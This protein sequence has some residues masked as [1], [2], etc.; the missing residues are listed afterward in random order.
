MYEPLKDADALIILTDWDEFR[1]PNWD[2]VSSLLKNPII[3]DGR[4]MF[5]PAAMAAKG[6]VYHSVGRG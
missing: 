4:N 1:E 5:D 3:I 2:K 6:F